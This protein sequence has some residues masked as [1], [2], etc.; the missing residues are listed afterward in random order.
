MM[1]VCQKV[2]TQIQAVPAN[3]A[4]PPLLRGYLC[5]SLDS[6]LQVE[7]DPG[8]SGE[9]EV[10]RMLSA[11]PQGCCITAF[12]STHFRPPTERRAGSLPVQVPA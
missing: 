7:L 8:E 9:V 3:K 5:S 12:E 2:H 10:S 1:A 11:P 6:A 4:F